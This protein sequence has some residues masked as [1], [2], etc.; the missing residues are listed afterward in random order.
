MSVFDRY[1]CRVEKSQPPNTTVDRY[2]IDLRQIILSLNCGVRRLIF[3]NP[4][5][6]HLGDQ[7]LTSTRIHS[8]EVYKSHSLYFLQ[9]VDTVRLGLHN[10]LRKRLEKYLHCDVEKKGGP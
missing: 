2:E 10:Y 6:P 5:K 4:K 8:T 1:R 9:E 3:L 7:R